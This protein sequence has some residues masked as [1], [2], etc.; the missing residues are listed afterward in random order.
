MG[1]FGTSPGGTGITTKALR[2]SYKDTGLL[3]IEDTM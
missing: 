3:K 2:K 1:A